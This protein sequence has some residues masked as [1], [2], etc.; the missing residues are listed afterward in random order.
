MKRQSTLSDTELNLLK[1]LSQN[2]RAPIR[3]IAKL[4]QVSEATVRYHIKKLEEKGIIKGYSVIINPSNIDLPIFITM[5]VE[6]EPALTK[7][8]ANAISKSP[9]FFLVWVVTGAHNI[10]AKGAFPSAEEMQRVVGEIMTETDGI[11]GYH[12]SLMFEA[13]KDPYLLP[14]EL[15]TIV[16]QS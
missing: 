2:A 15:L 7:K 5:G 3:S 11:Q 16:K 1:L 14:S 9:Y 12:L 6:C 13:V 10:H 4:M 8:V